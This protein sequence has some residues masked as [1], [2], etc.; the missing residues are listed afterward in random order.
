MGSIFP[1]LWT[2]KR[3]KGNSGY[4][5]PDPLD[6]A[7][8]LQQPIPNHMQTK[9]LLLTWFLS[10]T[11]GLLKAQT[12]TKDLEAVEKTLRAYMDGATLGDSTM[13]ASAFHPDGQMIFMR[14]GK[15]N[16]VPLRE[17]M[18][19]TKN[20]Q[21][22]DRK[23]RIVSIQIQ[24][25]SAQARLEVETPEVIFHDFMGLL[26]T[27]EGWKIVSKLFHREDKKKSGS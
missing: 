14:D 15:M 27:P 19:R 8:S 22:G 1:R 4:F 23:N 11:I 3:K 25:T 9:L 21:K 10:F 12:D 7:V 2:S 24:G 13:F 26:K 18:T 17:F 5:A 16:V 6:W 20:G